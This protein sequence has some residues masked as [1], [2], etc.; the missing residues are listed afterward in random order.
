MRCDE[1]QQDE[2]RR[3]VLGFSA[4]IGEPGSARWDNAGRFLFAEWELD[5]DLG[6]L[7][8]LSGR[9]APNMPA[10]RDIAAF[11]RAPQPTNSRAGETE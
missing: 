1:P 3:G 7:G 8:G 4:S 5:L 6:W 2:I 9:V 11:D 10:G